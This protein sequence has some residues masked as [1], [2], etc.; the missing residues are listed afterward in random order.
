[1]ISGN[2]IEIADRLDRS[3]LV[4]QPEI[5]D[6][7]AARPT[8]D[9]VLILIDNHGLTPKELRYEYLWLPT[10]EQL[11]MQIEARQALIFHIGVNEQ[12]FYEA[13]IKTSSGVVSARETDLRLAFAKTLYGLITKSFDCS[14]LQ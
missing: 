12:M 8:L 14:K 7:V 6:E 4:W 11:V 10:V 9:K 5:G 13:I 3:G 1:M 2:Y